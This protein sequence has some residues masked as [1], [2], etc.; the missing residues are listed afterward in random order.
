MPS[1]FQ[2][3]HCQAETVHSASVPHCV[4][5][6][7]QTF[8]AERDPTLTAVTEMSETAERSLLFLKAGKIK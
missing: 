8:G 2:F 3:D 7:S 5:Q 4:P 6:S 1:T